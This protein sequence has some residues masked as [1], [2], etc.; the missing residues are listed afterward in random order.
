MNTSS[1]RAT[2][3]SAI[4]LIGALAATTPAAANGVPITTFMGA[5]AATETY[6]P[7]EVVT[8]G[9]GSYLC[10]VSNE[11]V[12]PTTS[13]TNW[14]VLAA[15]APSV[16]DS[17]GQVVGAYLLAVEAINGEVPY[18]SDH[19]LIT[20]FSQPFA[21]SFTTSMLGSY[22]A[23]NGTYLNAI[24]FESSDCSGTPHLR[25]PGYL[26]ALPIAGV[27]GTIAYLVSNRA[28]SITGHSYIELTPGSANSACLQG[29]SGHGLDYYPI[30]T[31]FDLS[32]LNLV[33]PFSVQ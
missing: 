26:T 33:P 20:A 10:L 27:G 13:A 25:V 14:T 19:V 30:K 29:T 28:F 1:R 7:G 4:M 12:V 15:P 24:W 21:I 31:T 18:P 8:Y 9:G 2:L 6:S 11:D 22:P 23:D 32:T 5:W 3:L 17:K 16:R